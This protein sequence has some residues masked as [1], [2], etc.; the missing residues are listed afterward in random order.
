MYVCII[1]AYASSDVFLHYH[2]QNLNINNNS[3]NSD[4][5][6]N[7]NNNKN[8]NGRR[9]FKKAMRENT[10]LGQIYMHYSHSTKIN[11]DQLKNRSL[12]VNRSKPPK[13]IW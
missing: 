10:T 13:E 5:N 4:D 6:N 9:A 8:V 12:E 1:C 2:F 11:N 7:N 3:N